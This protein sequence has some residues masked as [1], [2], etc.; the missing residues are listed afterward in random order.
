MTVNETPMKVRAVEV[1]AMEVR[2][3]EVNVA[4]AKVAMAKMTVSKM[5]MPEMTAAAA[6]SASKSTAVTDLDDQIVGQVP[7]L[8]CSR[9]IDQRH[10][11]GTLGRQRE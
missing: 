8:R 11:F 6:E 5:P 3:M 1:R 2:A 7:G 9:W 10:G 4:M